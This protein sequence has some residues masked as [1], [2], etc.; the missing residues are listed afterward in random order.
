MLELLTVALIAT[1]TQAF[2]PDRPSTWKLG[3][4]LPPK[5]ALR[6]QVVRE[7]TSPGGSQGESPLSPA[8]AE[9]LLDDPRAQLVYGDQTVSVIAPSSVARQR[10]DHQDLL[11]VFLRPERV[12]TAKRFF[13]AHEAVLRKAEKDHGVDPTVVVSVLVWESNLGT[14]TGSYVAFNIFTSQAFFLGEANKIAMRRKKE[15]KQLDPAKQEER[16]ATIQARARKNLAVLVRT[17]KARGIDALA[18]KSSWAGAI[19][20][21][22]FMPATLEWAE[23]G[24]GDGKID[25]YDFDDSIASIARYLEASGF[26]ASRQKAVWTYNHEQAYVDGVLAFADALK[27]TLVE[28]ADAGPSDAAQKDAANQ[29]L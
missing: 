22:Q 28:P 20:Y 24:N 26:A 14:I 10:K 21:P 29:D 12:Q 25:L 6:E 27:S 8:E 17:S 2:N 15:Q 1:A 16:V 18:L 5:S 19:G 7:W 23:D 4:K 9:A 13:R 11:K 3:N